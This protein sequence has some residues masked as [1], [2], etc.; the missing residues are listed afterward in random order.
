M[1]AHKRVYVGV[2]LI[3][4]DVA[5]LELGGESV[6]TVKEFRYLESLT[7]AHGRITGY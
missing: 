3:S 4:D 5:P 1:W 2:N 6:E 7:E